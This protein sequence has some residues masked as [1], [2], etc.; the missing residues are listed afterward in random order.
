MEI[1]CP[2]RVKYFLIIKK[3]WHA[4][5]WMNLINIMLSK[6]GRQKRVHIAWFHIYIYVVQK[7]AILIYSVNCHENHYFGEVDNTWKEQVFTLGVLMTGRGTSEMLEMIHFLFWMGVTQMCSLWILIELLMT[8]VIF[9][10]FIIFK[11]VFLKNESS[12]VTVN[13]PTEQQWAVGNNSIWA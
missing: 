9:C 6:E 8:Q 4:T 13:L 10:M 3:K 12:L 2:S 1:K 5:T 7:Q 11:C